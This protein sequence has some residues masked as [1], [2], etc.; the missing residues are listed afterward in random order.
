MPWNVKFLQILSAASVGQPKPKP[1]PEQ[2]SEEITP[3]EL[4]IKLL[5]TKFGDLVDKNLDEVIESYLPDGF[6][7]YN[8]QID[9][10]KQCFSTMKEHGGFL[11]AEVHRPGRAVRHGPATQGAYHHSSCNKICMG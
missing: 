4:Y 11:L 9:A 7:K 3:Y 5:Q 8:Y 6:D 2:Q 1:E 10:V